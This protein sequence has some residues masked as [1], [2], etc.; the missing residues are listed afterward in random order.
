MGI[1]RETVLNALK[2]RRTRPGD[3]IT[4]RYH[5]PG[6]RLAGK[7]DVLQDP[8]GDLCMHYG[9]AGPCPPCGGQP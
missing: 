6:R 8:L 4:V 2:G 7:R 5:V 9:V 1:D 3:V